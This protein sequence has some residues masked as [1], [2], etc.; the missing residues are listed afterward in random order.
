MKHVYIDLLYAIISAGIPCLIGGFFAA[1]KHFI[2]SQ[3]AAKIIST[4]QAKSQ[5]ANEAV[6]FVEDAFKELGG[7]EKLENA[8]ANLIGRLNGCGIPITDSETDTLLRAAY[9]TAKSA[10]NNNADNV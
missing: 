6:L 8:K 1:I 7:S 9:Q 4:L 10:F 3:K 2:G 5:L